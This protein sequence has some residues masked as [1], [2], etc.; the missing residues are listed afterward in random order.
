[1]QSISVFVFEQNSLEVVVID[2]EPWFNA[3]QVAKALGYA[4]PSKALQ[5]NVSGKYNQQLDL[6]KPGKKPNFISEP[7]LY[8]LIMRSNLP[9][10]EKFQEWVFE[11]VLPSIRKTGGY[12][13]QKAITPP[14]SFDALEYAKKALSLAG[15]E[16]PIVESWGLVTLASKVDTPNREI[17]L[18]AQKLIASRIELPETLSSVTEVCQMMGS[19]MTPRNLNKI[20]C[21]MGL[22]VLT[23]DSKG[24]IQ[25]H[26]T[27]ASQG[28]GKLILNS[29]GN[30]KNVPQLKWY[31]DKLIEVISDR[32]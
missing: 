1:M 11:E 18:D 19:K 16:S 31:A 12:T 7:G 15:L 9:T 29:T 25:Y 4:N 10:A 32:T 27:E 13:H 3:S 20:L 26:L 30:G 21:E 14:T 6:G 17:Y 23:R 28:L 22:Q 5:D 8:Q 24:R 2:N